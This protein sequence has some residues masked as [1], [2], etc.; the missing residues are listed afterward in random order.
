MPQCH[1]ETVLE[2]A[3]LLAYLLI[4]C[5]AIF[6]LLIVIFGYL[7]MRNSGNK[8]THE[9]NLPSVNRKVQRQEQSATQIAEQ[10]FHMVQTDFSDINFVDV[11]RDR[12]TSESIYLQLFLV[13]LTV[14]LNI[15]DGYKRQLILD[16]FWDFID[17][18]G[19][20]GAAL[21][22]RL[23]DYS[24]VAKAS[25]P[26][27]LYSDL[28]GMFCTYFAGPSSDLRN[29]ATKLAGQTSDKLTRYLADLV[30]L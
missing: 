25:S 10:L 20:T 22:K 5:A 7:N 13:D 8:A 26:E 2:V 14:Y 21:T 3:K 24:R 28:G 29:F 12:M 9:S 27:K 11:G 18:A 19:L 4:A 17:G 16:I 1:H 23:D 30:V 6:V 15:L